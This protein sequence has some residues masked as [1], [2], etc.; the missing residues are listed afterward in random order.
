MK[1]VYV[2]LKWNN[3]NVCKKCCENDDLKF[4]GLFEFLSELIIG[5][6]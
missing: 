6:V 5:D 3:F 1:I 4:V 2:S